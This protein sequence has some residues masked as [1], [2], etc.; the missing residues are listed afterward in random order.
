V[1]KNKEV[2]KILIIVI[3]YLKLVIIT[4][5]ATKKAFK[6]KLLVIYKVKKKVLPL[7]NK[8]KTRSILA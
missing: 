7:L 8:I 2:L 1:F 3:S 5:A 4:K 6:V